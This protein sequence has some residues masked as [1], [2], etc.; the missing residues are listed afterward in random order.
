M[1]QLADLSA[2]VKSPWFPSASPVV[3]ND[4]AMWDYGLCTG[5]AAAHLTAINWEG[6]AEHGFC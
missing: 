4:P 1:K 2:G 3:I 5:R 6:S